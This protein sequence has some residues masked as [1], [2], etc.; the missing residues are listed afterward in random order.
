MTNPFEHR[1]IT[2]RRLMR[3]GGAAAAGLAGR[4]PAHA[5]RLGARATITCCRTASPTR[6]GRAGPSTR[7]CRSTTSSW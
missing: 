7:R 5:R 2:R 1:P 3:Y 6:G 4:E